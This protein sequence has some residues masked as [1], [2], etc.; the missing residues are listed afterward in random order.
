MK[1]LSN[2]ELKLIFGGGATGGGNQGGPPIEK[3]AAK[4]CASPIK[5]PV[6]G[7]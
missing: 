4:T 5:P 3:T 1:N 6:T 7:G 2:K